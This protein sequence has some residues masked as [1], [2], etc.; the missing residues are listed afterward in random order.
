MK[1]IFRKYP[2]RIFITVLVVLLIAVVGTVN[3]YRTYRHDAEFRHADKT[4][5]RFLQKIYSDKELD[6]NTTGIY[7]GDINL[8][9]N[10]KLIGYR[11]VVM[12]LDAR[13]YRYDDTVLV[14]VVNEKSVYAEFYSGEYIL[15]YQSS[16][17]KWFTVN[18]GAQISENELIRCAK[19]ESYEFKVPLEY[20]IGSSS[21]PVKL[22]KGRYRIC[23]EITTQTRENAETTRVMIGQAFR[24]E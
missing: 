19:D 22:K 18:A 2:K 1:T 8:E 13:E 12:E 23:I 24:I 17:Q 7:Y 16:G 9:P 3:N 20:T 4:T 11:N 21:E 5:V 15:Q 10:R 6:L 14:S